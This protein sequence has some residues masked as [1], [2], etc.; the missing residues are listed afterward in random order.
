[1]LPAGH[2]LLIVTFCV[3]AHFTPLEEL[4]SRNPEKKAN[5]IIPALGNN[6]EMISKF[7]GFHEIIR[8]TRCKSVKRLISLD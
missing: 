3:V 1:M 4:D 5:R 7:N 8:V 2:Q 6:A